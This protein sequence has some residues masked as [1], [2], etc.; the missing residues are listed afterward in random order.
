MV[1]AADTKQAGHR[2]RA[3]SIGEWCIAILWF[4]R[5]QWAACH[6]RPWLAV[7]ATPLAMIATAEC[8]LWWIWPVLIVCSR[9]WTR[10]AIWN[11][12]LSIEEGIVGWE[13]AFVGAASLAAFP[14]DR[15]VIGALWIGFP[16]ALAAV[17][18][19]AHRQK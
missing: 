12:V 7:I 11:W 17:G 18:W 1:A 8:G 2:C 3:P 16:L 19:H 10:S 15:A 13:W 6:P 9:A 14:A 4:L 5:G